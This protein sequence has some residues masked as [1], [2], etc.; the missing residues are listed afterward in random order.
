MIEKL[1]DKY[2][3]DLDELR[4][5]SVDDQRMTWINFVDLLCSISLRNDENEDDDV[6]FI[7]DSYDD[8]LRSLFFKLIE[9]GYESEILFPLTKIFSL[10]SEIEIFAV[11]LAL[12]AS[13]SRRFSLFHASSMM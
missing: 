13:E 9:K 8:K 1:I 5:E 3:P 6:E 10:I 11:A 2:F 7:K 12:A 4:F